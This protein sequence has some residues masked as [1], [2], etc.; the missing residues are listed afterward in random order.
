LDGILQGEIREVHRALTNA[1][2]HEINTESPNQIQDLLYNTLRLPT[3][4]KKGTGK[5]T[6]DENAL[7]E[8]R[9]VYPHPVLDLIIKNRHLQKRK[10]TFIDCEL[11]DA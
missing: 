6:A 8:L 9:T 11:E 1:V 2:G 10:S 3:R 5:I 7:R 4:H